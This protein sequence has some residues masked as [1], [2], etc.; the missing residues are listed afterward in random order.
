MGS[1]EAASSASAVDA[2]DGDGRQLTPARKRGL[3]IV[4][5]VL[6]L[7]AVA[8]S[9]WPNRFWNHYH[10]AGLHQPWD[11]FAP[12]PVHSETVFEAAV[13]FSDGSSATWRPPHASAVFA[14]R[15]HRWELW[16][17]RLVEDEYSPW[18]EETARWIA[19]Q[20]DGGRRQPVRVALRRRWSL[21]PPPGVDP[22]LRAWSE[23]EFYTLDL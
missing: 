13:T 20:Y 23:F 12:D 7:A 17:D 6:V 21:L 16:Q 22:R 3:S 1:A 9:F 8:G 14:Y 19:E 15:S 2:Y 4:V 11:V 5:A 10:E 18:W